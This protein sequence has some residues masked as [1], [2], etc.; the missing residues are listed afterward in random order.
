MPGVTVTTLLKDSGSTPLEAQGSQFFVVG[1]TERGST[2]EP[3][4]VRGLAEVEALTG[5][6]V[7]YGTVYDQ[8]SLFFSEGGLQ[9]YIGRVVGGS[10]AVGTLTLVDRAG[11]PL[12]TLR[13]DA[14]NPGSWS[15]N[16]TVEVQDGS[17]AN[18]F[19]IIVKL[20]G[21]TVANKN[22]LADPAAA[23]VAFANNVYVRLTDLSSATAPPNNN[24]AVLAATALSAGTDDRGTLVDADYVNALS[25]F[26]PELGDGAVAIPG[27]NGATIWAGINTHCIANNRIGLLAGA[28]SDSKSTLIGY[29]AATAPGS[30]YCGLF[31]PWVIVPDGSGSVRTIPPEGYVAAC[32]A[33]AVDQVGSWRVPAGLI[34]KANTVVDLDQHWVE[35]DANDLDDSRISVIRII[36]N[37]VRLYGWRSLS[38]DEDNYALL[39]QRDLLNSLEVEAKKVLEDFTFQPIDTRG[40]LQANIKTALIG[41]VD[42]IAQQGGLYPLIVNGQQADPG[43]LVETGD[44][45]NSSTNLAANEVRARLS[46]RISPTG[47]LISLTI[48]KVPTTSGM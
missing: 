41:L 34:A 18:T 10:A 46:V 6:R 16:L 30:E 20:S 5:S 4:L 27:Q 25:L 9:A 39:N 21:V 40:H 3:I 13:V 14:A 42:P 38:T 47:A 19:R 23:V 37:T 22:N 7:S 1:L 29:L 31:T 26:S 2:S 33:R 17:L 28:Q 8:L 43:Y 36:A 35:V 32:R 45:V 48:I 11:T 15:S 24:P 12:N 44:S